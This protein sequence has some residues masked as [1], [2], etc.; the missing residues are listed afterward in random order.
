MCIWHDGADANSVG[1]NGVNATIWLLARHQARL[2]HQVTLLLRVVPSAAAL[3]AAKAAGIR[4]LFLGGGLWSVNHRK[5][6]EAV[7]ERRPDLV[8]MHSVFIPRQA[9]LARQLARWGSLISPR[10]MEAFPPKCCVIIE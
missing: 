8:H 2:G 3:S 9:S 1:V 5:L 6:A 4:L 10:R 7:D